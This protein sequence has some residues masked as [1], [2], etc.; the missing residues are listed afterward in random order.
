MAKSKTNCGR[1]ATIK[2]HFC[3]SNYPEFGV[4]KG[5]EFETFKNYTHGEE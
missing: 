3:F 1:F 4:I 2:N 5:Y